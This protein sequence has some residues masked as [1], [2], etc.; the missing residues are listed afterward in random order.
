MVKLFQIQEGL[1]PADGKYGAGVATALAE[2]YDI[3]P[4]VPYYWNKK[5]WPAD[6]KRYTGYLEQRAAR[7]PAR[8]KQWL[9]ATKGV[10]AS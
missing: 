10:A 1:L 2:V 6:K 9:A 3:I 4:P 7:D 5:T 8:A